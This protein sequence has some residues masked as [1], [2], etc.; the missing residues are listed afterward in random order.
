[1]PKMSHQLIQKQWKVLGGKIEGE[2]HG[3][4]GIGRMET[5]GKSPLIHKSREKN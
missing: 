2:N 5:S 3:D 4:C 1:M